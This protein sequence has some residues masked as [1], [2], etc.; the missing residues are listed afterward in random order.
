MTLKEAWQSGI[1]QLEEAGI[2][3]AQ[4][5][6]WYLLEHAAKITKEYYYLHMDQEL[7]QE[8]QLAYEETMKRRAGHV[9]LQYLT[10]ETE[11]MGLPFKVN[12]SVLIPRQD[13]ELLVEE[14][15]R[16]LQAGN[17]VLDMC[18]GSGCI[19]ISLLKLCPGIMGVGVDISRQALNTAMENARMNQVQAQ[20]ERSNLFAHIDDRYDVIVSN[21][22]YIP[23]DVIPQLMPEV[24]EYEPIQALDGTEDGLEFY[25]RII[26]EAP[27][28]LTEQGWLLFEI[29]YNQ[30]E[31]VVSLMLEVGFC[32]V[33]LIKDL[34]GNDRVI[35]GH[36]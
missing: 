34:S 36:L 31:A 28:H 2:T 15:L 16:I 18:T 27:N 26:A 33:Q 12:P 8:Q 13:T 35:K 4:L 25:R 5:D 29:G 19:L 30:G 32:D 9:P 1:H 22:P 11:F 24:R 10:G 7:N 17:Q 6:A 20:W 21:P 23:S 14:A 3:E